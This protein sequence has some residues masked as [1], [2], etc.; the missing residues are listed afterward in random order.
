MPMKVLLVVMFCTATLVYA[1]SQEVK[2]A[3]MGSISGQVRLNEE[4]VQGIT[5]I[6]SQK[7]RNP[8][9]PFAK[10]ITDKEG[11]FQFKLQEK[12]DFIISAF[13]PGYVT[14][15]PGSSASRFGKQ[16]TVAQGEEVSGIDLVLRRGC[17]ITGRV[18]NARKQP[19]IETAI[20]LQPLDEKGQVRLNYI[21]NSQMYLTDDRGVYRLYG[22]FPGRYRVGVG[23]R[24]KGG[25]ITFPTGFYQRTYYPNVT[26]ESKATI[27][28]LSEG[29][30]ANHIDIT[31]ES[32]LDTYS[33]AGHIID[34]DSSKPVAG[35][36]YGYGAVVNNKFE[37]SP[38]IGGIPSTGKGEFLIQGLIPGRYLFFIVN[39]EKT[40]SYSEPVSIE[41]KDADIT[42][43][44]IKVGQGAS[45]SGTVTI[46]GMS[47]SELPK[48]LSQLT[49]LVN[50]LPAMPEAPRLFVPKVNADGKFY[51]SGLREGTAQIYIGNQ[52][53]AMNILRMERNGVEQEVLEVK[54][55]EHITGMQ[56]ILSYGTG[57]LRGQIKAENGL[58]PEGLQIVAKREGQERNWLLQV[59]A[60]GHF[61]LEN[62]PP[63][64][65]ELFLTQRETAGSEP[66][67]LM[68]QSLLVRG[69]GESQVVFILGKK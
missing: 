38:A 42:D 25:P 47:E 22:L 37:D 13:A 60:R 35:L 43:A 17:A 68:K 67:T 26:D 6:L 29:E 15:S 64:K 66:L 53:G 44:V 57:I 18:V 54:K 39:D 28:E 2:T 31:I 46:E 51:I 52:S 48:M 62:I 14:G 50:M 19:V 56:L 36:V 34:A 30:E 5:V 10:T 61:A 1:Q 23:E 3:E 55:G 7:N 11:R 59:D 8:A 20:Y 58:L 9:S 32:H 69:E 41:V 12:G 33:V 40:E 63:G 24:A 65:Y 21:T 27:L 4:P 45:I 49:I 16:V